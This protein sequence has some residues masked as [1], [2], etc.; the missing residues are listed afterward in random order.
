[1]HPPTYDTNNR[2]NEMV[3]NTTGPRILARAIRSF[4]G[5]STELPDSYTHLIYN[6]SIIPTDQIY[7]KC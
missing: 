1:M 6:R 7:K 3:L 2:H 5:L 4:F